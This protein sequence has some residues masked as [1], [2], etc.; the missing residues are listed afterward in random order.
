MKHMYNIKKI[1]IYGGSIK[2][3]KTFKVEIFKWLALKTSP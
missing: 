1:Y 3:Q 2:I